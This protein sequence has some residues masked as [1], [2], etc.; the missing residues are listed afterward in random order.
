MRWIPETNTVELTER[1]IKALKDKLDDPMS[2][3]TLISP[4]PYR[5]P[6]AAVESP[7][8]AEAVATPGAVVLTRGQLQTLATEGAQVRVAGITVKAVSDAE[9]YSDRLAGEVY[10]PSTGEYR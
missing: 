4:D 5:I 3:R 6:V 7:G 9:H 1:N 8:A 2:A 10:M